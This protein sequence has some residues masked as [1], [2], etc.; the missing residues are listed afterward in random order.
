MASGSEEAMV[1]EVVH[2][3]GD[4]MVDEVVHGSGDGIVDEVTGVSEGP[5]TGAA[6]TAWMTLRVAPAF[7][8]FTISS[9]VGADSIELMF[10]F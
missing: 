9:T 7:L 10:T 4:G 5:V 2:G 8:S 3:S 6:N 1:D